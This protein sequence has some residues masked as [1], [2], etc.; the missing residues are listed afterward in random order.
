MRPRL[1]LTARQYYEGRSKVPH[2]T[3]YW[4]ACSDVDPMEQLVGPVL[5]DVVL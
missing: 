4:M 2:S 1:L 5:R 3:T